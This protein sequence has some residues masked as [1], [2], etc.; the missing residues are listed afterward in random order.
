MSSYP[1][2]LDTTETLYVAVNN[3]ATT[4][5]SP[6]TA[7]NTDIAVVDASGLQSTNGLVSIG[8]EVIKY[9][10]IDNGGA[11]PVLSG[12][13]RGFDGT[14]ADA[15]GQ[16]K[17]V[18]VRWVAAHHNGLVDAIIKM[19]SAMGLDPA[20]SADYADVAERLDLNLP[21]TVP[22]ALSNDWSFTHNRKRLI[23]VQLWKKNLSNNYEQFFPGIEQELNPAGT[24]AVTI[25]LGAGNDQEGYIVVS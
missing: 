21:V 6:I 24:A 8:S 19:Q 3:K 5:V 9:A 16:G 17:R 10:F 2:S 11:N 25:L 20:M 12:C 22:I 7:V 15:H 14:T 23:S 1:T 18:E 13:T 4:L